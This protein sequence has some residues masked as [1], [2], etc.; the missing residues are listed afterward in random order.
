MIAQN[1]GG[2]RLLVKHWHSYQPF[3]FCLKSIKS[4]AHPA[5]PVPTFCNHLGCIWPIHFGGIKQLFRAKTSFITSQF[6]NAYLQILYVRESQ[7]VGSVFNCWT[8]WWGQCIDRFCIISSH[9]AGI[10]EITAFGRHHP[11][12]LHIGKYCPTHNG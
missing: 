7:S 9:L 12:P 3:S 4:T 11:V 8:E 1:G 6:L 5:I 10:F 2:H